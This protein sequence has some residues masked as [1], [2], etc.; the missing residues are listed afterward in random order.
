M[1]RDAKR[2]SFAAAL[3]CVFLPGFLISTMFLALFSFSFFPLTWSMSL[4]SSP[5]SFTF[6][7]DKSKGYNFYRSLFKYSSLLVPVTRTFAPCVI[8]SRPTI[9]SSMLPIF[10]NPLFL[11]SSPI[12]TMSPDLIFTGSRSRR[13]CISFKATRYSSLHRFQK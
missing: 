6:Q 5:F 4:T 9:F 3:H 7:P 11:F 2:A 10:Q 12:R 13:R 1:W 8:P